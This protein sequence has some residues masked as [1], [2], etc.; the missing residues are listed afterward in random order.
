[1]KQ[2]KEQMKHCFPA[3]LTNL[4]VK[5]LEAYIRKMIAK[6]K[7]SSRLSTACVT[8]LDIGRAESSTEHLFLILAEASKPA[9]VTE[10]EAAASHRR[11]TKKPP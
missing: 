1:V 8:P 4:L 10:L 11:K 2:L 9:N 3:S 6:L 7:K 5:F